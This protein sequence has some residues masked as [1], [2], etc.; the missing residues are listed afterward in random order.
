MNLNGN[1]QLIPCVYTALAAVLTEELRSEP[2]ESLFSAQY[3]GSA[4]L[5]LC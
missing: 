3:S 5:P 2:E 1:E 4:P